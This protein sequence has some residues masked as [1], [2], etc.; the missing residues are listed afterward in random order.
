ML[1]FSCFPCAVKSNAKGERKCLHLFAVSTGATR[2]RAAWSTCSAEEHATS[3]CRYQGG[4]NAG[5]TV[6]NDTGQVCPQ[7]P[8]LRDFASGEVVNVMGNGMVIDIAHLSGEMERLPRRRRRAS[9]PRTSRSATAPIR[10]HALSRAC[11]TASRRTVLRRREVR[12]HPP[13]HR[14]CLQRT[15]I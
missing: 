10:H 14:A 5:H 9:R 8:A 3:F 1:C 11:T 2:A 15:N 12:L 4:N 7:P 6:I 13:R